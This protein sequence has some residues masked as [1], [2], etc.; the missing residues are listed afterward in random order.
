M[1]RPTLLSSFYSPLFSLFPVPLSNTLFPAL[2]LQ[3]LIKF[4]YETMVLCLF[5]YKSDWICFLKEDFSLLAA[6]ILLARPRSAR[7]FS[8]ASAPSL[9]VIFK[10]NTFRWGCFGA[11]RSLTCDSGAGS[12][13]GFCGKALS[14]LLL[15]RETS[16]L[17]YL[18]SS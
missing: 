11:L 13:F 6:C 16:T 2:T 8:F 14:R 9:G 10:P 12:E 18:L 3:F 1:Y 15:K 7:H 17:A 4:S 5:E